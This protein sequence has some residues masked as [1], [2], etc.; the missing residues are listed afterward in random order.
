M[1]IR[2]EIRR[3]PPA[4]VLMPANQ[5]RPVKPPQCLMADAESTG[6]SQQDQERQKGR[7]GLVKVIGSMANSVRERSLSGAGFSS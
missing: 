6:V 3:E 7:S 1:E 2:Q 4:V 5:E